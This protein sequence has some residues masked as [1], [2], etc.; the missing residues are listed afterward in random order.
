MRRR[1]P[2]PDFDV[3]VVGFGPVGALFANLLGQH[4]LRVLVLERD[5]DLHPLP[6]A[7][8][9]DGEVMRVFQAAGLAEAV[10]K[11]A[12]A[13]SKGMHFVNAAGETLMVRRGAEGPGP[14]G[15]ANNWYFHQPELDAVLRQGVTRFANVEVRLR[16]E[17]AA[18]RD[19]GGHAAVTVRDGATGAASERTARYVVGC[20]GAR[21]LVRVPSARRCSTS[22]CTSPGSS[23]TS[24]RTPGR[25]ARGGSPTSRSSTATRAAR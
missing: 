19:A 14:H 18:V 9:F 21:S 25:S 6:R 15:W 4:G 1:G 22:A 11:A 10:S 5:A 17:A 3:V 7:V 12:R 2:E 13:T 8:H 16:H 24:S 23:S 20:D